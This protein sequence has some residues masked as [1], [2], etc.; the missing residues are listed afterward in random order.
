[1]ANPG[2]NWLINITPFAILLVLWFFLLR[3]LQSKQK[4]DVEKIPASVAAELR[5][6]RE[7]VD[8]LR[9]EVKARDDKP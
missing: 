3:Y 8:A 9:A 1:M 6:L 4:K 5:A 7:S 2:T